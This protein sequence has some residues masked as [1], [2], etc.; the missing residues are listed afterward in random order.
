MDA[1]IKK[2]IDKRI[3]KNGWMRKL[4]EFYED[5]VGSVG[6]CAAPRNGSESESES[7]SDGMLGVSKASPPE[8]SAQSSS[9]MSKISFA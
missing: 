9:K 6:N 7:E 5:E 8:D 3:A 1:G 4:I 2:T